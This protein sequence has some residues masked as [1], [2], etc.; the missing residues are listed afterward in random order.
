MPVVSEAV[1]VLQSK[2]VAIDCRT[3]ARQPHVQTFPDMQSLTI[4]S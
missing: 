3:S 1:E 4:C 2:S